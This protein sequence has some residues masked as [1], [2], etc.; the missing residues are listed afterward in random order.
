MGRH[1]PAAPMAAQLPPLGDEVLVVSGLARSGTSMIM[2]MLAAGG[3]N[4]LTDSERPADEDNPRGYFEFA[5][6][7]RMLRDTSWIAEACGK[8]VKIVAPLVLRVPLRMRCRVILMERDYVEILASQAKMIQRRGAPLAD[9]PQRRE[10]LLREYARA[11]ERTREM[12][13]ARPDVRLLA[14]RHAEVLRDPLGAA[15]EICA[16]AGGGLDCARMASVVDPS[17]H[18]NRA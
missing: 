17:L 13:A 8:A 6:A 15:R 9:S 14:M 4:A 16:F 10:R 3:M 7:K 11:I 18:R 12:L 5:A 1:I 2:Q